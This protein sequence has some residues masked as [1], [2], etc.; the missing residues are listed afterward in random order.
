MVSCQDVDRL[1]TEY[2]DAEVSGEQRRGIEDHLSACPPCS[3]RARAEATARRVVMVR[4][5]RLS[6][7]APALLRERCA[8]LAPKPARSRWFARPFAGR[9]GLASASAAALA[10]AA[11]TY[12]IVSHSPTLLAAELTLDH[13][14]CF[15]LFE[16][17]ASRADPEEVARQL[18]ADYGWHLRVP[19]GLPRE[20]LALLG[21]RRCLS[22]DGQVAHVLYRHA[23]RP[24]S[25]FMMPRTS[26]PE[27]RV[28]LAGRVATIWSH[29]NTTYVL[30]GDEGERE[31]Q[32]IADHFRTATAEPRVLDP[33]E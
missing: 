9:L 31:M 10:V 27:A 12:G 18:T 13:V 30:L 24:V 32:P 21:A 20:H 5:A 22:T 25:L 2:L 16:P 15:A 26:R 17:R 3:R 6:P 4:A 1:M 23:G 8:A 7:P 11:L 29:G 28:A 33:G 19:D 14:K